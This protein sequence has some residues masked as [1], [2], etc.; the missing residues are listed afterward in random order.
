MKKLQNIFLI[1][2]TAAVMALSGCKTLNSPPTAQQIAAHNL[3]VDVLKAKTFLIKADRLTVQNTTFP[4]VIESTNFVTVLGNQAIVQVSP[5]MSGGPNG[6]GGFTVRGTVTG[7]S[8]TQNDKGEVRVAYHVI[9]TA[10]SCDITILLKS[11]NADATVF[12]NNTFHNLKAT[13][14]GTVTPV[15]DSFNKGYSHF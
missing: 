15:D 4:A 3:A 13:M 8:F 6:L 1:V 5:G 2:I 9:A 7:Y 10:G 11:K 14:Y 12:I